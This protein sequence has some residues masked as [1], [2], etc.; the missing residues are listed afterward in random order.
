M[1]HAENCQV[2]TCSSVATCLFVDTKEDLSIWK[3][4]VDMH[5]GLSLPPFRVFLSGKQ[6]ARS[7]VNRLS[8]KGRD[9]RLP[10][11]VS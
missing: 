10:G 11:P 2:K 1:Q 4:V 5:G 3:A 7:A 9:P 6:T 8:R